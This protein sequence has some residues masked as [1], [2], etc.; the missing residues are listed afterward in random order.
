MYHFVV[1]SE[2]LVIKQLRLVV[3]FAAVMIAG[4]SL[5]LA[6]STEEVDPSV[7]RYES[8]LVFLLGFFGP[9][10]GDVVTGSLS[11]FPTADSSLFPAA[12]SSSWL[13]ASLLG[14]SQ[15]S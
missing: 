2:N 13:G 5:H 14:S 11:S 7:Q 10:A 6:Q 15:S 12:M 9:P 4:I 1:H 3:F 8:H